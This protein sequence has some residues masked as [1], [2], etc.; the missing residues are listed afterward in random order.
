MPYPV[1]TVSHKEGLL[2]QDVLIAET[3][4][5]KDLG[6]LSGLHRPDAPE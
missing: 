2:V 3:R 4:V 6:Q 5:V 1:R